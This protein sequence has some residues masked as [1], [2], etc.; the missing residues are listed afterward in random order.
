[1]LVKNK[2]YTTFGFHVNKHHE[3]MLVNGSPNKQKSS[4]LQNNRH[5]NR[6]IHV[7]AVDI[8]IGVILKLNP[9]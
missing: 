6:G 1:M 7:A 3:L 8:R 5:E 9:T 2:R 4:L